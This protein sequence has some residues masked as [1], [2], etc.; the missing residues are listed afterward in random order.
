MVYTEDKTFEPGEIIIENGKFA[1]TASD[2]SEIIDGE[3]CFAVPGFVDVHFHGCVGA[4]LCDASL[5]GIAKIAEYEASV[6]VTTICPASM[7]MPRQ[8]LFEI[9]STAAAYERKSGAKFAGI[10]MEGPFI[11]AAKKG[12]QAAQNICACDVE[13][14]RDLQKAAKGLIKLV[15]IAPENDGAMEFIEEVK[16][17]VVVSLA[18]TTADYKTAREAFLK[19]AT[20]VTHL[21]NAM[22]PFSHREPGVVGAAFDSP[23]CMAELICDGVHIHPAVVRATFEMFGPD[24]IIMISDSMCA[25]GL[26]DGQYTLGGQDVYVT[27]NRATLKDGTIAGSA[28]NLMDCVRTA[29]KEMHIPLETAVGC[30]TVN[31][32]K[33][34]GI[35]DRCGSITPG[36]AGDLVLLNKDLELK[37]VYIDGVRV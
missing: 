4:D 31:P 7:T 25:T 26:D 2:S 5:E 20:H 19:G 22:L 34:I 12:A 6:G 35:Y 32:A 13:L 11:S 21:Y 15:D 30:A 10:N 9:M 1:E 24:R 23:D 29:V 27:G 37:A 28:T 3:G 17:E 33:Q 8:T 36:K 16:D 18:H 14:F